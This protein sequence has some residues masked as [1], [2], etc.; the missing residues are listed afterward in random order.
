MLN[1]LHTAQNNEAQ[2]ISDIEPVAPGIGRIVC[3]QCGG[4]PSEFPSLFPPEIG[5][6]QCIDCKGTGYIYVDMW[7]SVWRA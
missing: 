3:P 1:K 2:L 7:P 6:A 5:A 4:K